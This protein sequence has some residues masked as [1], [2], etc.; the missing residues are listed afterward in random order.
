M[1]FPCLFFSFNSRKDADCVTFCCFPTFSKIGLVGVGGVG[2]SGVHLHAK[3]PLVEGS[4]EEGVQ[5]VLVD[6]SQAQDAS[7]EAKPGRS[8]GGKKTHVISQIECFLEADG[9]FETFRTTNSSFWCRILKKRRFTFQ[10]KTYQTATPPKIMKLIPPESRC[11]KRA[12][13]TAALRK[14]SKTPHHLYS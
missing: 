5:Q 4:G 10:L 12:W 2:G 7:A 3:K 11:E 1:S 9:E 14:R 13:V 6:Q 8:R